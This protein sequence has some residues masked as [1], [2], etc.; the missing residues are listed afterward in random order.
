MGYLRTIP[1]RVDELRAIAVWLKVRSQMKVPAKVKTFFIS[2]RR[3]PMHRA[4]ISALLEKYSDSAGLHLRAQ[5]HMLQHVGLA[6][7]DQ[8]PD[9]GWRFG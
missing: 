6:L 4:T 9:T 8:G 2:E 5:P 3:R 7:A 1:L